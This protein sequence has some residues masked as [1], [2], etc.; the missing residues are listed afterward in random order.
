MNGTHTSNS[1]WN[2]VFSRPVE[3]TK[4]TNRLNRYPMTAPST[5]PP[6]KLAKKLPVAFTSENVPVMAAATANWNDT[7]PDASLSSDS[8]FRMLPERLGLSAVSERDATAMGSVGDSA[9]PKASAAA[10]GTSGSAVCTA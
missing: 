7:M 4:R 3:R 6:R 2:V 10:M 9:A 8:A 1:T 5:K